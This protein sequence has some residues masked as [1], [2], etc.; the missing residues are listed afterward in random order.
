ME[1]SN[2]IVEKW[3]LGIIDE[4]GFKYELK[5]LLIM[6]N[7]INQKNYK[8]ALKDLYKTPKPQNPAQMKYYWLKSDDDKI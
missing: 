2:W 8:K 4:K 6:K 1:L 7:L 5:Q 3:G